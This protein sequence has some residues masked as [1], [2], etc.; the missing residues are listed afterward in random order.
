MLEYTIMRK[1][2]TSFEFP[3]SRDVCF[4]SCGGRNFKYNV[5]FNKCLQ[6]DFIL[7][8]GIEVMFIM[9]NISYILGFC[10]IL[11]WSR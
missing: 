9:L 5:N 4:D 11:I 8:S 6:L 1:R 2:Y 3:L 10:G 7:F